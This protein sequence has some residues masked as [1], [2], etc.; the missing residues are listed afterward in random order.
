MAE[1][2]RRIDGEIVQS[3]RP[4]ETIYIHRKPIGVVAGVLPWN[5]PFFLVARK[6]APALVTGNTIVIKSSEETPINAYEFAELVAE[7]SLPKGVFNVVSGRGATTGQALTSHKD[8]G[9]VSFTG[10]VETGVRIMARTRMATGKERSGTS[11]TGSD[12]VQAR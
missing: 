5:F 2:A 10:S 4:G 9:C 11:T 8:V 3:D 6:M 12:T 7:T 1:W